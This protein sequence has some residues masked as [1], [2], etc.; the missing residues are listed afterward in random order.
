MDLLLKAYICLCRL[1][2]ASTCLPLLKRASICFCRLAS[3]SAGLYQLLH[4]LICFCDLISAYAGLCL[5]L[6]A[7]I[8]LYRLA[9]A[10]AHIHLLL[11]A[12][13]CLYGLTSAST[14]LHLLLQ[15]C[16]CFFCRLA[17]AS[18]SLHLFLQ[19][20][21]CRCVFSPVKPNGYGA[22]RN[23]RVLND[24][25]MCTEAFSV[26]SGS[27]EASSARKAPFQYISSINNPNLARL[28][29][30]VLRTSKSRSFV[31]FRKSR[32]VDGQTTTEWLTVSCQTNDPFWL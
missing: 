18:A 32:N 25:L 9:S 17:S 10:S 26:A 5:L 16:I 31:R 12:C 28:L 13:L 21:I 24:L 20:C 22:P 29:V 23:S 6:Q 19:A 27:N 1:T 2:S 30:I 3:A 4:A 15:A 14:G 7:C 8:C 11:H